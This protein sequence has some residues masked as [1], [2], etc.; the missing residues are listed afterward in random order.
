MVLLACCCC[1]LFSSSF[2]KDFWTTKCTRCPDAL[3]KLNERTFASKSACYV[4]SICC[5]SLDGARN[6]LE[7]Y[8]E[9]RWPNIHHYY[10]AQEDKELAKTILGFATVPF[11]VVLNQKGEIVQ[12]GGNKKINWEIAFQE[13]TT[14][15]VEANVDDK[16]N[17]TNALVPDVTDRKVVSEPSREETFAIDDLDF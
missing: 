1:L 12:K 16:E 11:Y 5:D 9:Q 15:R 13:E 10:M 14:A 2:L 3:D 8:D 17:M 6:I 4:M 7:E